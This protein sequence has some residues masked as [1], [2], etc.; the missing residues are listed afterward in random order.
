MTHPNTLNPITSQPPPVAGDHGRVAGLG[1]ISARP[2]TFRT[3]Q[4]TQDVQV[5]VG[6]LRCYGKL[7]P[8]AASRTLQ[9]MTERLAAEVKRDHSACAVDE[10]GQ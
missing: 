5:L 4:Y 3:R 10:V 8:E 6:L 7:D 2:S 1:P 9:G